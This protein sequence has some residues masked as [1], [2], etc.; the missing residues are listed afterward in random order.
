MREPR[1]AII[2][3]RAFYPHGPWYLIAVRTKNP[4]CY[5]PFCGSLTFFIDTTRVISVGITAWGCY[6]FENQTKGELPME[7]QTVFSI[8]T[9]LG[10]AIGVLIVLSMT[11]FT[12]K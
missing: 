2:Y 9:W 6:L 5:W 8:L 11:F 3:Q 7:M 4:C 10:G 1:M 12:V